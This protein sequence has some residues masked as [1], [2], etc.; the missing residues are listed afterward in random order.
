MHTGSEKLEIFRFDEKKGL[1]GMRKIKMNL[2]SDF[3]SS[4][5]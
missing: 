2:E 5:T 1:P 4:F 3:Q